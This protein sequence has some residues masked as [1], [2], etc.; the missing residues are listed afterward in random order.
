VNIKIIEMSVSHRF[1]VEVAII[2]RLINPYS[3]VNPMTI[4][5]VAV[6]KPTAK[7]ESANAT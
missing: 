4:P 1:N 6:N 7:S 2:P 5:S 3:I